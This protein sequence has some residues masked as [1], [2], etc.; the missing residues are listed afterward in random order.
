MTRSMPAPN[1]NDED[2]EEKIQN[3]IDEENVSDIL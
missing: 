2:E 3:M 1:K